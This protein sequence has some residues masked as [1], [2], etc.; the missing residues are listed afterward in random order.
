[1]TPRDIKLLLQ[2]RDIEHQKLAS[3]IGCSKSEL[4]QVINGHRQNAP[5]RT[6][7]ATRL[8]MP[9]D[10]LFGVSHDEATEEKRAKVA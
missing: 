7:L 6:K 4:S 1:M 2:L 9:E 5:L 10:E 3:E 8:G